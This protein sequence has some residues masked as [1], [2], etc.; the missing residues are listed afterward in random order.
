MKLAKKEELN[1]RWLQRLDEHEEGAR[2]ALEQRTTH[3]RA[4]QHTHT[5][6]TLTKPVHLVGTEGTAELGADGSHH[7]AAPLRLN[8]VSTAAVRGQK[9][10]T[11]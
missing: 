10:P 6:N 8:K 5:H 3:A 4:H 11:A 2:A 9:V 7:T 1:K